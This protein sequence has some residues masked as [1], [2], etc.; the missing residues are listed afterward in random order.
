[1][2][3]S[4]SDAS[5]SRRCQAGVL[6]VEQRRGRRLAVASPRRAGRCTSGRRSFEACSP[7]RSPML[8]SLTALTTLSR[9][10]AEDV[11]VVGVGELLRG[12]LAQLVDPE[13]GH[14]G[15]DQGGEEGAQA[16][17]RAGEE[18]DADEDRQAGVDVGDV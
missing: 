12:L 17:G 1:M 6:V 10:R 14:A 11:A 13:G 18:V 15:D 5:R 8:A 4:R 9:V 3:F 7:T 16:L 2:P